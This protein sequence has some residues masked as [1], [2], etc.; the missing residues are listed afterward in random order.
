MPQKE[1]SWNANASDAAAA[2][3]YEDNINHK[4]PRVFLEPIF[5]IHHH[6]MCHE[7]II[8]QTPKTNP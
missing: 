2:I 5:P 7:L 3:D 1:A 8:L 6:L 4:Q